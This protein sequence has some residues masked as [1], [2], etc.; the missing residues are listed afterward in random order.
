MTNFRQIGKGMVFLLTL[1]GVTLYYFMQ[2]LIFRSLARLREQ[3]SLAD[4]THLL[5]TKWGQAFFNLTPGWN[6]VVSGREHLPAPGKPYVIVANHESGTDILAIYFLGIPFRWLAKDS[7][8]KLPLIGQAMRWADYV[9]IVR[10][11]K[12]SHIQALATSEKH[13]RA[14]TS[15]LF[16]PEGTR[17]TLGYPKEFKTGA[18]RLALKCGLPVLPIVLQG[19][20]N[21]L[22]KKSL[23]PEPATMQVQILAPVSALA[24]E[25]PQEFTTRVR[26]LIVSAHA[27]LMAKAGSPTPTPTSQNTVLPSSSSVEASSSC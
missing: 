26:A 12:D 19:A 3:V 8:F 13:L 10:G 14:G 15:M 16:F 5:A 20:G 27:T 24:G 18:F 1:Y 2:L 11:S 9:P 4:T 17:S 21:L 25:G 23:C 22:K 6:I 7:V